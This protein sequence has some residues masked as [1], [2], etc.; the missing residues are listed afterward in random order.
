MQPVRMTKR[1]ARVRRG[2]LRAI[3]H[4]FRGAARPTSAAQPA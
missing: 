4:Y 1:M 3:G 2:A